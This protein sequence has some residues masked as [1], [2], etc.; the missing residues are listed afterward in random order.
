MD[1][2]YPDTDAPGSI[3]AISKLYFKGN[4]DAAK[5]DPSSAL[6]LKNGQGKLNNAD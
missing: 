2:Q 6:R 3:P 4:F 1:I 5:F